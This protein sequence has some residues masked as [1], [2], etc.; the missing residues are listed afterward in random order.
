MS[1][2]HGKLTVDTNTIYGQ[3]IIHYVGSVGI[4]ADKIESFR[5]RKTKVQYEEEIN[6][7]VNS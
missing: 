6:E 4:L 1:G 2:V 5:D 7:D 3:V